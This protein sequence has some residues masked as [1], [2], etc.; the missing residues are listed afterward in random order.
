M[1]RHP[2]LASLTVACIVCGIF[3][4]YGFDFDSR[5][6]LATACAICCLLA[7]WLAYLV[8]AFKNN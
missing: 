2:L 5:G 4:I 7:G 1:K 8:A 3:W 6:W